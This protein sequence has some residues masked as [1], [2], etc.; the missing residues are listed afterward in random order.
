[1]KDNELKELKKDC[2]VKQKKGLH[3]ILASVIIWV[4]I[5]GVE[6]TN[7]PIL[8]KNLF[9]FCCS[10]PLLPIAFLL[11]KLIGVDF[12]N[13]NNPLTKLGILL[14]VNQVVYLLIPMW[15]FQASPE[16]MLMVFAIIFGA[17]LMP[18][19]WLYESR[20][21]LFASIIIPIVSLYVGLTLGGP[22]LAIVM[23]AIEC[24][25]SLCLYIETRKQS[26]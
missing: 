14:S 26:L 16:H 24:I 11:S 3:F 22:T 12:Q 2:I 19:S 6:L 1:M 23:V 10:A 8:T 18:F 7:W 20:T 13:K 9:I 25:F 15:I 4:L 17:H 21:Y 5:T